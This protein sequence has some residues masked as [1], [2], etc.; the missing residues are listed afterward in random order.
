MAIRALEPGLDSRTATDHMTDR[1]LA[2]LTDQYA[3]P[4][5]QG[6]WRERMFDDA[7]FSL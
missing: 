1:K 6:S 5:V 3:L 7:V 2:L 4:M